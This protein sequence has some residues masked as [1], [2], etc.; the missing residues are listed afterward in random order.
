MTSARITRTVHLARRPWLALRIP[1]I[2]VAA[3]LAT[4]IVAIASGAGLAIP[5]AVAGGILAVEGTYLG[6]RQLTIRLEVEPGIVRLRGLGVSKRY[7]LDPHGSLA[8]IRTETA[9]EHWLR[10][11]RGLLLG[12][13]AGQAT[14]TGG[15][16]VD[17]VRLAPGP[18]VILIPT[19]RGRLGV[20]PAD[21]AELVDAIL[22]AVR[23]APPLAPAVEAAP[24]PVVPAVP[25][26]MSGID[27]T[28]REDRLLGE[29]S[30]AAAGA[31]AERAAATMAV[32][33]A[34]LPKGADRSLPR[35]VRPRV[36]PPPRRRLSAAETGRPSWYLSPGELTA[37]ALPT[38]AAIV[39]WVVV[40]AVG[41]TT[42]PVDVLVATVV[43][44]GPFSSVAAY[45][46]IPRWPRLAGLTSASAI[47]ALLL[48]LRAAAGSAG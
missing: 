33:V 35:V 44:A 9:G 45:M 39:T 22:A 32:S 12:Y 17:L 8:R 46:T 6:I 19:D 27:R 28:E 30:A 41:P 5:L 26:T 36:A 40:R 21:E 15:E 13:G 31:A 42:L 43:L 3:G 48:V 24:A 29:R 47:A 23:E 37:V 14:L 1:A 11:G 4:V 16:V 20:V 38:L 10:S 18:A 34:S 25:S 7:R 2:I